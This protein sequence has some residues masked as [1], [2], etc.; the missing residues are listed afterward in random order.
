[1]TMERMT[2]HEVALLLKEHIDYWDENDFWVIAEIK[3]ANYHSSGH[4][5]LELIEKDKD[6]DSVIAEARAT[7]WRNV[8]KGLVSKFQSS[9]GSPLKSGMK[10]LLR[11]EFVFNPKY[12]I[13]INVNDIDPTYTLGDLQR[14]R[15]EIIHRLEEEGLIQRNKQLDLLV[16]VKRFA[17]VSSETAAGYSDFLNT[18]NNNAYGFAYKVELFPAM[19][20]GQDAD[21]SVIE[22]LEK[23]YD[24][25][26]DFDA[27]VVIRGGG[28]SSDLLTFDSEPLCRKCAESP[29]PV[30][31]GIGHQRDT[32]IMDMLVFHNAI[33]PTAAAEYIISQT[34]VLMAELNEL[35]NRLLPV[36]SQSLKRLDV[37]LEELRSGL[38]NAPM[39]TLKGLTVKLEVLRNGLKTEP[40]MSLKSKWHQLELFSA[41]L[42]L[43]D[44]KNVLKRGYSITTCG[45]KVVK[46][47]SVLA[48]GAEIETVLEN[49]KL[50]S[51]VK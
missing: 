22:A 41:K 21:K 36:V 42:E 44:P 10:V 14:R 46:E 11:A 24:R 39:N 23:I 4:V 26:A 43:M 50:I 47:A 13:S 3:S 30:I 37:R 34:L 12:G 2:L 32:S 16:P 25:Y 6:S 18:L 33:T 8:A 28:A 49:G 27:I 5:Y 45:G 9:T 17:I 40:M 19:M 48:K 38:R 15:L 7:I 35:R 51:I 1:M 20:Q 29:L 31:S